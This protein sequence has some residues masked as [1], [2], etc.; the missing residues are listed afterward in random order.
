MISLRGVSRYISDLH[1]QPELDAV[2]QRFERFLDDC[3]QCQIGSLFI[4]GDLFEYW[5]GDDNGTD[6]FNAWVAA[7]LRELADSGTEIF[8]I[9]G[10]R[11][12]LLGHH[13]ATS[14]GMRVLDEQAKVGAGGTACLLLHGDTLCTDDVAYQGF[15]AMVRQSQWQAQFLARPL[16]ERIAEVAELRR[17]SQE[18]M[19]GKTAEIMDVN[20]AAVRNALEANH[21]RRLIH[22][23]THRPHMHVIELGETQGEGERW[24]LSDWTAERGD[25]IEID[26]NGIRRLPLQ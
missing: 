12:F 16:A 5:I 18:A 22:G 19:R 14:C 4:L 26:K 23:H 6:P 8:F 9:A 20:A 3:R 24:V 7:K 13:Y 25:A 17:R 21:C 10:N 1:L 11:D 2:N 15:R